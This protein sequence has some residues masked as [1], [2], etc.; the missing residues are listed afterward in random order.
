MVNRPSTSTCALCSNEAPP[1]EPR[2]EAAVQRLDR[3]PLVEVRPDRARV[4]PSDPVGLRERRA[5]LRR[6]VLP[7]HEQLL[8]H[9]QPQVRGQV[10]GVLLEPVAVQQ[11]FDLEQPAELGRALLG[12]VQ[13]D[14]HDGRRLDPGPA[15]P[16]DPVDVVGGREAGVERVVEDEPHVAGHLGGELQVRHVG[17]VADV[18][19]DELGGA[20]G[21]PPHEL[22]AADE[23]AGVAHT[24][25]LPH[26]VLDPDPA[27][28]E[29]VLLAD[30]V[31][32]RFHVEVVEV[33]REHRVL[34]ALGAQLAELG[35]Q[36][37]E[38]GDHHPGRLDGPRADRAEVQRGDP[39]TGEPGE[40]G[41]LRG[42]RGEQ[43]RLDEPVDGDEVAGG[44]AAVALHEVR[45]GPGV[46]AVRG[47]GLTAQ[48]V[49]ERLAGAVGEDVP[50]VAQRDE[51]AELHVLAPA[52]EHLLQQLEPGALALQRAG[53]RDEDVEQG[54]RERVD[55]PEV[56]P[57]G[58]GGTGGV[59][60]H[61]PV[62]RPAR[63][64]RGER[65]VEQRLLARPRAQHPLADDRGQVACPPG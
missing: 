21:P 25:R 36:L 23:L 2:L 42:E 31:E 16:D 58:T 48:P 56:V 9:P 20:P 1:G 26:L 57:R 49:G 15:Q 4:G 6:Q 40:R 46:E 62:T 33:Q 10:G 28:A 5:Q 24:E 38:P 64:D 59:E 32:Q 14:P 47:V 55:P 65:L 29:R 12:E 19:E 54:R 35:L 50:Q 18:R 17:L 45:P 63:L 3:H 52:V 51:L 61:V 37:L 39:R 13:R 7:Q 8:P 53:Q 27:R 43:E 22:A 11:I 44:R 34:V 60:Q 41:Q 30:G